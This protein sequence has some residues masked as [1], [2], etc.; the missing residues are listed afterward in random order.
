MDRETSLGFGCLAIIWGGVEIYFST[1][2]TLNLNRPSTFIHLDE[3]PF[4]FWLLCGIKIFVGVLGVVYF[5]VGENKK[6]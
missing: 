3:D 1:A 4:L 6:G 5:F 2:V